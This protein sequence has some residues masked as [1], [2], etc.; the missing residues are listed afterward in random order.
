MAELD[1]KDAAELDAAV[2]H[3]R[4]RDLTAPLAATYEEDWDPLGD[5]YTN[6]AVSAQLGWNGEG[7][8]NEE[9]GL[10]PVIPGE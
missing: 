10:D 8:A 6:S 7:G 3:S 2:H 5:G 4:E 1:K 9:A